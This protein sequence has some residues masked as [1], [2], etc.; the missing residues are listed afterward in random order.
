MAPGIQPDLDDTAKG[1]AILSR[2]GRRS[3]SN[4]MREE[5]E[6]DSHFRTYT[7]EQNAS[8]SANCHA[9]IALLLDADNSDGSMYHSV[10]KIVK[11]L[12]NRWLE[13]DGFAHDKWVRLA[14]SHCTCT[15]RLVN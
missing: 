15:F 13:S 1:S 14:A 2:L 10:E 3:L 5:F 12:C 9:L 6:T 7:L 4:R 8:F 11:F